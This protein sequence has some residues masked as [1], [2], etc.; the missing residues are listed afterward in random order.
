MPATTMA[1]FTPHWWGASPPGAPPVASGHVRRIAGS[2]A[3]GSV[4][5]CVLRSLDAS[6]PERR[7]A[8]WQPARRRQDAW[9]C[10]IR[11]GPRPATTTAPPAVPRSARPRHR[12]PSPSPAW[13][14]SLGLSLITYSLARSFLLA[15]ARLRRPQPGL[16]QRPLREGPPAR[17]E[18]RRRPAH[19]R[20]PHRGRR[21]RRPPLQRPLVP[22][23]RRLRPGRRSRRSCATPCC[24]AT[25]A[26]SATTSSGDPYLAVGVYVAADD[27]AYF[28]VFPNANLQRT[29]SVIGTSLAVGATVADAR[30]R[31][32]R[33]VGQPPPPQPAVARGRRRQR[34]GRGRPRHPPR[35]T[36]PTPT[37]HR[38]VSSFND[39]AD[40]VQDR[41]EREARFASDV[42]HELRSPLTA[43]TAAV[44]VLDARRDDLPARSQQALDVVDQPGARFDQMVL[45]LLEISR[46]DAGVTEFNPEPVAA[47][48]RRA[49]H[50]GA[51]RLRQRAGVGGPPR[52][53]SARC[54][55]QAPPRA[56]PR[57]PPR[58]TPSST[59]AGRRA[60]PSTTA[61]TARA[62]RRGGRRPRRA[63]SPS[64]PASSSASPAGTAARHRV[65]TGLGLA[66]VA[67]HAAVHGGQAWVEDRPGGGA[68]F[69]V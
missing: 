26:A 3:P 6:A 66:L 62:P 12:R 5:S 8:S 64:G 19:Q 31:R 21:L 28:E 10:G 53:P 23:E 38:L 47:R 4:P 43:L 46:L 58:A 61:A 69:V 30:R 24:S 20:R 54:R 57:Q 33:L 9:A 44:E 39:M 67:E 22:A 68:R 60:S 32:P 59:A 35:P 56:H 13:S 16:R 63:A 1:W 48:R 2:L 15:A 25:A 18:G 52:G 29:L 14:W 50:R 41:I 11:G 40:A 49:A 55:R 45:D 51:L 7:A 17:P 42:S 27:A 65:G 36:R 34:A 37:S